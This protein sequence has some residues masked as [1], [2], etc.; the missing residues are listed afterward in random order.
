[1]SPTNGTQFSYYSQPIT[2]VVANGVATGG[3]LPIT[4]VEVATDAAFTAV[5]TT[6]AVSPGANGQ[7]TITLDHL[8]PATTYYWRVKTTAGDNP[9]VYS[10]PARFSIGPQLV[11]QPPAPVQP[12]SN[13]FTHKRATFTVANAIRTG[14]PAT[15]TYRFEIASDTGFSNMLASGTVGEGPNQTSFTPPSDLVSGATYYWRARATDTATLIVSG[16]SSVQSFTT[17]NPD[18]GLFRY[19]MTLHLVSTTN[20]NNVSGP[21]FPPDLLLDSGLT[22]SGDRL[23]YA[24]EQNESIALEFDVTRTGNQLSGHLHTEGVRWPG[25]FHG[26]VF[27][28]AA[29]TSGTVDDMTGR[30]SGTARGTYSDEGFP[31]YILCSD[32]ELAFTLTPHR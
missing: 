29:V 17:V 15:L 11:I 32:S 18:D 23:R 5:V 2:L 24:V 8:A 30:L 27:I 14:P 3:A 20:C 16:Y 22:V 4:A 13:S 9:G 1:V 7:P 25:T 12:L 19:V 28:N 10:S 26:S 21:I 6:Q 31:G